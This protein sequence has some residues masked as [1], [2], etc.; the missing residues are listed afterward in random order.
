MKSLPKFWLRVDGF[1]TPLA[2]LKFSP[3]RNGE[4]SLYRKLYATEIKVDYSNHWVCRWSMCGDHTGSIFSVAWLKRTKKK[5]ENSPTTRNFFCELRKLWIEYD[6]G[7]KLEVKRIHRNPDPLRYSYEKI[8][9]SADLGVL[10]K[11]KKDITCS[12]SRAPATMQLWLRGAETQPSNRLF[13]VGWCP[14]TPSLMRAAIVYPEYCFKKDF[15]QYWGA[16]ITDKGSWCILRA[17]IRIQSSKRWIQNRDFRNWLFDKGALKIEIVSTPDPRPFFPHFELFKSPTLSKCAHDVE[18]N[19]LTPQLSRSLACSGSKTLCFFL[20]MRWRRS[21]CS[22]RCPVHALD[23]HHFGKPREGRVRFV[24]VLQSLS[25]PLP[26]KSRVC[27][28]LQSVPSPWKYHHLWPRVEPLLLIQ[29]CHRWAVKRQSERFQGWGERG[30]RATQWFPDV[31]PAMSKHKQSKVPRQSQLKLKGKDSAVQMARTGVLLR[32]NSN[33]RKWREQAC[34]SSWRQ[35][36][37]S[38]RMRIICRN[39]ARSEADLAQ[40]RRGASSLLSFFFV[41]GCW[42]NFSTPPVWRTNKQ[43]FHVTWRH[44]SAVM[45]VKFSIGFFLLFCNSE[46]KLFINFEITFSWFISWGK[47]CKSKA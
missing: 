26:L 29:H 44:L 33:H 28:C 30:R 35:I 40:L 5:K 12:A 16:E 41:C 2:L 22:I 25:L 15:W 32:Q 47:G 21:R 42:C 39:A 8:C 23:F 9:G 13:F 45:C 20:S 37:N 3:Y 14:N 18:E 24:R 6:L 4:F 17:E 43:K 38:N 19:C 46:K 11:K 34:F 31:E 1:W 27:R 36:S 7:L 10:V